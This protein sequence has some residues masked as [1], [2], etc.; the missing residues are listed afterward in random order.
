MNHRSFRFLQLPSIPCRY[1]AA[2]A[3]AAV[4]TGCN[5]KEDPTGVIAITIAPGQ[6]GSCVSSPC[7]VSLVMPAGSGIYEVTGNEISLGTYPA[8]KTVNIGSFDQ[9]QAIKIK[10]ADVAKAYVYIPNTP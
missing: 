6:T 5:V 8:G 4:L 2:I 10:G 3:A 7:A 1:L 9:S